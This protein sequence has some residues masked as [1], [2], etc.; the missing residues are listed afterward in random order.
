MNEHQKVTEVGTKILFLGT[1]EKLREE[2]NAL[3]LDLGLNP[4]PTTYQLCNPEQIN[5]YHYYALNVCFSPNPSLPQI[6]MLK[7]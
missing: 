1:D 7:S 5:H 2:R 3:V 6:Q 4:S